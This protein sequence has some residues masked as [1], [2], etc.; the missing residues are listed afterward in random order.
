[1]VLLAV[2]A[3]DLLPVRHTAILLLVAAAVLLA[4]E[5]KFAS[6]GALAIGGI[7]CLAIGTLT[8][9]DAPIPELSIQPA[10]AIALC[11]GF[12]GIT[13]LLLRLALR[14]RRNKALIGPAALVG[15]PATA[16][17]PLWPPFESADSAGHPARSIGRILVQGEIWQAT[18]SEP[19]A[20]QTNLRVTGFHGDILEVQPTS[21]EPSSPARI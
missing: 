19:V 20:E 7:V 4:L 9:I 6:H 11:V 5:M 8:L 14:A 12:G 3:L 18:S 15:F 2:F 21:Q 16:M 17:E 10:I 1:M 13:F